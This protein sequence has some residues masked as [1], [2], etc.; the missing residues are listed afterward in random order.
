MKKLLEILVKVSGAAAAKAGLKAVGRHLKKLGKNAKQG[1]RDFKEFNRVMF[2]ATAFMSMFSK[3]FSN[4]MNLMEK[5]AELDRITNQ[6]ERVFGTPSGKLYVELKKFTDNF[7][8]RVE[9]MRAAVTMKTLGMT[10]TL[11]E[12]ANMIAAA[13]TASKM[14]GFKAGEGIKRFTNFLRDGALSHLNFLNIVAKTNPALQAELSILKAGTGILGGMVS[15]QRKLIL[16]KKLLLLATINEKK[17]NRDLLDII[18]SLKES[19]DMLGMS[20]GAILAQALGPLFDKISVGTYSFADFL[21]NIRKTSPFLIGLA[22]FLLVVAGSFAAVI[23]VMGTFKLLMIAIASLAAGGLALPLLLGFVMSLSLGFASLAANTETA[24]ESLDRL[25][26]KLDRAELIKKVADSLQELHFSDPKNIEKG[27]S[28]VKTKIWDK[29]DAEGKEQAIALA[30]RGV[31]KEYRNR[32]QGRRDPNETA[33]KYLM[34]RE[35]GETPTFPPQYP[36]GASPE[37]IRIIEEKGKIA[38]GP[39]SQ[40]KMPKG[41]V[42]TTKGSERVNME[43]Y[44]TQLEGIRIESEKQTKL[45]E[46]IKVSNSNIDNVT[47]TEQLKSK[48]PN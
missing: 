5:G 28:Q 46:N 26:D 21:E 45:L 25:Y 48:R 32:K 20:I 16:G 31:L 44:A 23:A 24:T 2:S 10:K 1:G 36:K 47:A 9:A 34:G 17:G 6:F 39:K 43:N 19:F 13:G 12:T 15:T 30:S 40:L 3:G 33:R 11:S 41:T 35:F 4:A 29:L 14:A 38:P 7:I 27:I 37:A 22:K 8:P 42:P 18:Q